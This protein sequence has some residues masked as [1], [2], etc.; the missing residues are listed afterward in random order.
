MNKTLFTFLL[1]FIG[2]SSFSQTEKVIDRIVAQLGDEIILLSDIQ[3][4][5]LEIL[6]EGGE[7]TTQTDCQILEEMLFEKLLINQAQIDS[8]EIPDDMVNSEMENRIRYIAQQIGSIEELEKFY[9][10][11]VAQIKA[12]FFT[13]IKK[14]MMAERMRD[15]ITENVFITPNEVKTFYNKQSKDSLPY[16][17][18]K[19]SVAQ[20]VFYPIITD[21]DKQKRKDQL[22]LRRKQIISGER[23]FEGVATLESDDPGSRLQGGNLGWNSRGTMVP[24][25]EAELFK[26]EKNGISPVFETQYGYHIVQLIDRKGD[27]YNCRHILFIPQVNDKALMKS[28]MTADSLHKALKKGTISFEEAA[29][30]YSQDEYSKYNGGKIVNPYTGD[31]FWDVQNISEIDPGLYNIIGNMK[32]GDM[33]QP[34]LYDNYMEQKKGIRIVKLLEKTKPHLANLTDDYQLIQ[35]A[36]L[37]EKK[38]AAIDAWVR[39]K[40]T[41][42]Y[43]RIFDQNFISQCNYTYPWTSSVSQ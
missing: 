11:S 35:M 24:E 36:A 30:K 37:N 9:G 17:N 18:S 10:K 21:E 28:A 39:D 7:L 3:N 5:R 23:T 6:Q 19:I 22:E 26:L 2:M 40:I 13:I 43:V 15:M 42:S 4:R 34:V 1:L 14:R 41:I 12:E 27:N 25:F 16:I 31:Y 29:T 32:V 8:V 33:S 38:Q 20:I